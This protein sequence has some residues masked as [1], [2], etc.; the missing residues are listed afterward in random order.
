MRKFVVA[1]VIL[2][3]VAAAGAYVYFYQPFTKQTPIESLLPG[4]TLGLVRV[5]ELKKQI[6]RFKA[7]KMGRTLAGMDLQGLMAALALPPAQREEITGSLERFMEAVNSPWFDSLFG[8]DVSLALLKAPFNPQQPDAA[9]L[10]PLLDAVALVARPRQPARI[11]DSLNSMFATQLSVQSQDFQQWRI[12][13]FA[14]E[15]GQQVYYALTDGL[16]VAGL[17]AEPVKRCLQQSLA[18]TPS[19]LQTQAYRTLCAPLFKTGQTDLFAFGDAGHMIALLREV[20][21]RRA[22]S[23]PQMAQLKT[24]LDRIQG[25]DTI[26]FVQYDDGGPLVRL[27][28]VVGIDKQHMMPPMARATAIAPIP[29]ATL[30]CI[31]ADA[32]LY[33]WQNNF[34]LKF[35]WQEL[36]RQPAMTPETVAQIKQSFAQKTGMELD[37]FLE[38]FGT[39]AGLLL[40]DLNMGGMFPIPELALFVQARQ[41]D[42]IKLFIKQQAEQFNMPILQESYKGTDLQ[43]VMVPLGG[44]LSPAYTFSKGFCTVAINRTLLKSMLDENGTNR[45]SSHPNFKA[46]NQG[47]TDK[48]NQVFYMRTEGLVAKTRDI[49]NWAVT[50]MAM[51]KPEEADQARQIV[52]LGVNPLLDGLSMFKAVGGRTYNL[53]DRI[54]SD[55]Q[56]LLDRT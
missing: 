51:A 53:E 15:N 42:V 8:Q 50:W 24:Q 32:L 4:D 22:A 27:K 9:D 18:T 43:Y 46:V 12:H 19:L 41:P 54:N 11:L 25:I 7:G 35:Y 36:Q 14:V 1:S 40:N 30:A 21:E 45:L 10:Q 5:C 44:D 55:M 16:V 13:Q 3:L 2:I 38:A 52:E 31:P 28:M 34:D 48:N 29:N 37:H 39:Q 49:V 56:V 6:E 26:G 23:E 47:L 20:F 33:S 17:S